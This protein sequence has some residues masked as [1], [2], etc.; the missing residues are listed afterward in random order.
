MICIF[1]KSPPVDKD[2]IRLSGIPLRD[3]SL[4]ELAELHRD[5]SNKNNHSEIL[6]VEKEL[7]RRENVLNRAWRDYGIY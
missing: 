4:V 3:L 5:Y 1:D 6:D 7:N 2:Y